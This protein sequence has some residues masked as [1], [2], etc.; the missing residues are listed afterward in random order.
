VASARV[1]NSGFV[2][3]GE[4]GEMRVQRLILATGGRSLPKSGSDGQGYTLA[5]SFGHTLT[6]HIFPALVPLVVPDGHFIRALSGIAVP[7][8]LDVRSGAGKV[9][10][11]FTDSMLCTHFGVSGPAALDIS[12]YWLAA[13][14]EDT[15]ARLL[16]NWLPDQTYEQVDVA[17]QTWR[18]SAWKYLAPQHPERLARALCEAAGMSPTARTD[19]L[20]RD[21]RR[22]LAQ[23][24]TQMPLP[25][26][27]TRGYTYAEVTAGGVPLSD[28]TL[29]TME[30]RIQ[31]G[32]Y[33]CGEICDVDGRIG[34]Y[35]FQWAWSSGYVAGVSA[36]E[37]LYNGV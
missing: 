23:M 12:R 22:T 25:I 11:S 19:Q 24:W 28:L 1:E 10:A 5:Q 15:G 36:A 35:N 4:W 33:F 34:G 32:L 18:E 7:V 17:L 16:V 13:H 30:S 2:V 27:D 3:G 9:L 20:P 31:Q 37:G 29:K 21:Q 6:S 14:R 26:I 8:T